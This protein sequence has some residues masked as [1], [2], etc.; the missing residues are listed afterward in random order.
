MSASVQPQPVPGPTP[1][2][3]PPPIPPPRPAPIQPIAVQPPAADLLPLVSSSPATQATA[4]GSSGIS[5]A[6]VVVLIWALS[7]FHVTM[8]PEV[9]TAI[10]ILIGGIVHW[11]VIKFGMP[12]S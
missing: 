8:P 4:A 11:M 6:L 1:L 12:P 3:P 2:P 5:A 7:Y 10:T 9:A